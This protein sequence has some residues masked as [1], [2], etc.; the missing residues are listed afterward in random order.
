[1]RRWI[2]KTRFR[3]MKEEMRLS[4]LTLQKHVRGW[5]TRKRYLMIKEKQMREQIALEQEQ[6][7]ERQLAK[8]KQ[9]FGRAALLQR[10]A[11]QD[12]GGSN[13]KETRA[14][15]VIQSCEYFFKMKF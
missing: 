7:K 13:E 11:T 14:A 5:L 8:N 3:K 2:A 9:V 12:N 1:M 4:A 6:E 15:V 10:L